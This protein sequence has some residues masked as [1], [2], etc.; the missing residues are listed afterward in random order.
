MDTY[1][2]RL[3]QMRHKLSIW[4]EM[5]EDYQKKN[6]TRMVMI[7]LTYSGLH[8]YRPGDINDYVKKVKQCLGDHLLAFA[9]VAEVQERG[10]IH[11][12]VILLVHKGTSIPKPDS[13]RDFYGKVI[14]GAV[15][16]WSHGWS[17]IHTAKTPYYL[18]KYTG[19]ERQKDLS[20]YPK[21]CRLFAVSVRGF[22][23]TEKIV[24]RAVTRI[25]K[26]A[27]HKDLGY[28]FMGSC[29]TEKYA[30]VLMPSGAIVEDNKKDNNKT[31]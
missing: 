7:M 17:G 8:D 15:P 12:H 16:M 13:T 27:D 22:S 20:R 11:Y 19:K 14:P 5:V 6:D 18:L 9:W 31:I 25:G 23:E 3:W 21:S 1:K 10:A 4:A 24:F 28:R 2:S 30:E 26:R 29:V